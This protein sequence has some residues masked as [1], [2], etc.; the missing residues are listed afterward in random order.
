[1]NIS[2]LNSFV[3]GTSQADC[4]AL[5]V[6]RGTGELE[7]GISK[8]G[9]IRDHALLAQTLDVKQLI[10]ACNKMDST[11]PPF[12]ESRFTEIKNEVRLF[13]LFSLLTTITCEF[14]KNIV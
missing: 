4:A 5:V 12:S 3:A 9:Q 7:A 8:N 10:V 14:M 1:M 2:K 6:V 11:E 13:S